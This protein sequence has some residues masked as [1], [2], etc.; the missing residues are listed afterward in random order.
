MKKT[1]SQQEPHEQY[2]FKDN[3]EFTKLKESY[4]SKDF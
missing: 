1:T 3:E 4:E 2:L